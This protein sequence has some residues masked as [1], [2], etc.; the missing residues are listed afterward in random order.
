[1]RPG[2]IPAL[3]YGQ[4]VRYAARGQDARSRDGQDVRYAA[5]G[6]DARSR[7]VCGERA[8]KVK[9]ARPP[10]FKINDWGRSFWRRPPC[11]G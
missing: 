7:P 6:Q 2:F 3:V 5:R 1:M 8:R 11:R 4:D 9:N 10:C